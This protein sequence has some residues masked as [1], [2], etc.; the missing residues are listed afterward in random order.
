MAFLRKCW[1]SNMNSLLPNIDE[2]EKIVDSRQTFSESPMTKDFI[3]L[4]ENDQLQVLTDIVKQS[5][6]YCKYPN[7]DY[8]IRYLMGDDYTSSMAFINYINNLGLFESCQL[9]IG[10]SRRDI[11]LKDYNTTHFVTIVKDFNSKTYLIDTTP[12]I[13]Y[14]YGEVNSTSIYN[15]LVIVDADLNKFIY[16]IRKSMYEIANGLYNF[17]QIDVF[18]KE[19]RNFYNNCFNGLLIKYGECIRNSDF[20]ELQTLFNR[21]FGSRF[22]DLEMLNQENNVYKE[23]ILLKWDEQLKFLLEYSKD[24][25][26]QQK[27][28][29]RI[30]GEQKNNLSVNLFGEKIKLSNLTPRLFW[31]NGCNVVLVKPS[32]YLVGVSNSVIEYMIPNKSRIVTSYNTNLGEHSELGLK[33]MSYFHPHGM[34]YQKQMEGPS[35]IIL[36]NDNAEILNDRKY[37]IRNNFAQKNNGKYVDW[38]DGTKVLWDTNLNTNLV[39]STD[40]AVETSVH[41]LAGYPEYQLFTRYNY[42]N[43]KLRKVKK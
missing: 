4:S 32:S 16:D 15:D 5:M 2:L 18:K 33:P 34:K 22:N 31:E 9:A 12:D 42:P 19:K 36:V 23:K 29:Q 3:L 27:I 24:N 8:D 38:F 13:G 35:K 7:P 41:F 39:H 20:I 10:G 30:I 6:I 17:S 43:P 11:D 28:A 1:V 40:D 25:K 37:F 26:S 14:S 21:E